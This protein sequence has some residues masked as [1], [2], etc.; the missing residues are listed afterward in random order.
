MRRLLRFYA[1]DV[2]HEAWPPPPHGGLRG[3]GGLARCERGEPLPDGC[4]LRDASPLD[5][6]AWRHVHGA[7]L[8]CDGVQLLP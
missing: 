1:R 4:Q 8:L 3:A 7:L 2:P 5:D 6:D